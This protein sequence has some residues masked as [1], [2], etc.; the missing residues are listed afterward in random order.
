MPNQL[1]S[2]LVRALRL[3]WLA[4]VLVALFGVRTALA[5]DGGGVEIG[6]HVGL[7]VPWTVIQHDGIGGTTTQLWDHFQMGFPMGVT[8]K[9]VLGPVAFD[10]E[11]VPAFDEKNNINL[12]IHPGLIYG[13][14]F[15]AFGLRAAF[16]TGDGQN[17]VGLTPLFAVPVWE[18][19]EK[20][21]LFLELDLPI[22][23]PKGGHTSF[24][25]ASHIGISF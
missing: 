11:F 3:T 15:G 17:A 19:S 24:A 18:V 6:G 10:M 23:F 12:T 2:A 16:V 22:R 13:T 1:N 4:G 14:S 8:F 20:S 25:V 7:V 5:D 9:N 21:T